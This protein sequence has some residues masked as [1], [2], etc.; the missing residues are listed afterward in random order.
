MMLVRI[1]TLCAFLIV[2]LFGDLP[3]TQW[4][5]LQ[6]SA[7]CCSELSVIP[8][9]LI[10]FVVPLFL[11]LEC[12]VVIWLTATMNDCVQVCIIM[13]TYIPIIFSHTY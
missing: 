9:G 10:E 8:S 12:V 2:S 5:A 7:C 11:P 4:C 3:H 1:V 6:Q 13:C